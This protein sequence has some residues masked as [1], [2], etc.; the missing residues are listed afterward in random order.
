[1]NYTMKFFSFFSDMIKHL[2]K[3]NLVAEIHLN[4]NNIKRIKTRVILLIGQIKKNK[5]ILIMIRHSR[6]FSHAEKKSSCRVFVGAIYNFGVSVRARKP[7][8][9]GVTR[10]TS[11][12]F[13]IP[14]PK[15][16]YPVCRKKKQI[17][18]Y[19]NIHKNGGLVF[20]VWLFRPIKEHQINIFLFFLPDVIQPPVLLT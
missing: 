12:V 15:P 19:F 20:Y 1:M 16:S 18:K 8:Q 13:S 10:M 17:K 3:Y 9:Y 11:S 2:F 14:D 7:V 4:N 6:F 5:K